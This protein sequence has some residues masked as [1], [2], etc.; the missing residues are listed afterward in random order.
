[1][2]ISNREMMPPPP[3]PWM[4]RPIRR[5]VIFWASAQT[6]A[7][8]V[9]MTRAMSRRGLRPKRC[10][11]EAKVGWKTVEQRRKE[12]PHQKAAMGLPWRDSE[13]I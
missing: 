1:M 7:P 2:R 3:I 13:M 9:N 5:E 10:E 6:I 11:S 12:V 4:L 8:T